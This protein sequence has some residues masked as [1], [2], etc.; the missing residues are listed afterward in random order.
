MHLLNVSQANTAA[1]DAQCFTISS[2]GLQ[3]SQCCSCKS[4]L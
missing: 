4:K 1:A 2:W 3:L